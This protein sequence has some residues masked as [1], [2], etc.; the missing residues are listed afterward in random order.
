MQGVV[1]VDACD[2]LLS[3]MQG[4]GVMRMSDEEV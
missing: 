2:V 4:V 1:C 3:V